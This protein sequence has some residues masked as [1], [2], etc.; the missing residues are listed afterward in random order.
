[1]K[2]EATGPLRGELSFPG[3]KS[4]CHRAVM[5]GAIADGVT[6]ITN[7]SGGGDN[8]STLKV[9]RALGVV[10][11]E[12][13]EQG[14]GTMLVV[15]GVGIDGLKEADDVLD[16][17]NSGTTMR[18]MSGLLSAQPFFSVLTGDEFLR[19]RPMRRVIGP[20]R[21]LGAEILGREGDTKAPLGIRG[22][23]L[24]G[25][26]LT[27]Q[28]ASAQVKSALILAGLYAD[29]Q[30]TVVE[31]GPTRDHTERMLRFMGADLKVEGRRIT[32]KPG[33]RL[34]GGEIAVPGD[35]SSAAFFIVAGLIT[36]GSEIRL[37]DV[38]VNPTRT[39]II[40]ILRE[41]GG[42]ITL[43]NE[44][45]VAGE[46]VADII[47]RHS[48]L[49]GV[50]V[51][52]DVV[53]RAIDEFPVL[54]VAATQAA[55]ETRIEGAEE[56][57]VKETDRI[58]AMTSELRKLGADVDELKDGMVIRGNSPLKGTAVDSYH[59]HRIAMSLAVAAQVTTGPV[60]IA[61]FDMVAISY[62]SFASDLKGL[63]GR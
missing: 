20:L 38:G 19:K 28:V 7:F 55:G 31:P 40:D 42:N 52:G 49:K 56:L 33:K 9:L 30:T 36:P 8:R 4:I 63:A 14:V 46:P 17:G 58:M 51:K 29:G 13:S 27:L 32:V 23:K 39:G 41:M 37:R 12:L 43:E 60:E 26:E 45:D 47:V 18:V 48:N 15:H 16:C 6:R 53:V 5:L 50:S 22:K 44:R 57:R 25:T 24:Q 59:D 10:V 35:I 3:D 2:F 61:H 54:A 11:D 21:E 34:K 62:P 1:M